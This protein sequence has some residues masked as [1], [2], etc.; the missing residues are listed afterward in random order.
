MDGSSPTSPHQGAFQKILVATDFSDSAWAAL[1]QAASLARSWGAEVT[2]VHVLED[3]RAAVEALPSDVRWD[4]A[5]GDIDRFEH[6]LRRD[7]DRRLADWLIPLRDAGVPLQ[8]ET[9]VGRPFVELIHAVQQEEHDVV[10]LGTRGLS[11]L[12]RF[13]LGSTASRL[14]R[15]CPC[16]VWT[17]KPEHCGKLQSLLVATDFSETSRRALDLAAALAGPLGA[18]IHL[19]HVLNLDDYR[20]LAGTP[21]DNADLLRRRRRLRRGIS[22]QLDQ[23]LDSLPSGCQATAHMANG[24]PWKQIV[25]G[26]RRLDADLIVMGCVGRSGVAGL[27]LGNTAERVLHAG[28]RSVLTVKPEGFVCPI[29]PVSRRL[30][31]ADA[32]RDSFVGQH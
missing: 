9:L 21:P 22:A 17:V 15:K 4:L 12:G 19:L 11:K 31:P 28:D 20:G 1:R 26:A 25:N 2:V 6:S 7:A 5:A 18:V 13:L 27:L 16:P 29:S 24:E 14:V 10:M 3:V 23:L 8:H 30:H 32:P